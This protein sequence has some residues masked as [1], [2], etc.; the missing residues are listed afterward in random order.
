MNL[1]RGTVVLAVLDPTAGHEQSGRR[2][3]VV[4]ADPAEGAALRFPLLS[5]VP[6]TTTML[7]LPF[8]PVVQPVPGSGLRAPSTAL[9]DNLRSI[10]PA[11]IL[12]VAGPIDAADLRAIDAAMRRFLGLT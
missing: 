12:R 1:P 10:D 5:V 7:G 11:R 6:L 4:V 2:P 9:P 3:C 8:Y